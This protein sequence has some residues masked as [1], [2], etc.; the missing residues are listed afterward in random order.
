MPL[1]LLSTAFIL[2][3]RPSRTQAKRTVFSAALHVCTDT[4]LT[5]PRPP[6]PP[7]QVFQSWTFPVVWPSVLFIMGGLAAIWLWEG[8]RP[9]FMGLLLF[10]LLPTL[11]EVL[12]RAQRGRRTLSVAAWWAF[13]VR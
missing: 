9:L 13:L 4:R 8:V 6:S 10:Q 1:F 3:V 7:A 2:P 5:P 11:Q 12:K